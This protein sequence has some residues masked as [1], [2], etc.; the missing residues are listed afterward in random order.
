MPIAP[1][2]QPT[3]ASTPAPTEQPNDSAIEIIP[4]PNA[5]SSAASAPSSTLKLSLYRSNPV[6]SQQVLQNID[7]GQIVAGQEKK[8][9]T[10]YFRNEGNLPL[11]MSFSPS[12]WAFKD[13]SGNPL[14]QSYSKYFTLTWNYDNTRINPNEVRQIIFSLLVSPDLKDVASFSFNLVVT[15]TSTM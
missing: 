11:T 6:R 7:W 13:S 15:I 2:I 5:S 14:P 1:S 8:S 10:I 9:P 12:D 4:S 3:P